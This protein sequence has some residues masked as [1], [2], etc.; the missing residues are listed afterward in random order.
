ML[1]YNLCSDSRSE[2][3][4][5]PSHRALA[6]TYVRTSRSNQVDIRSLTIIHVPRPVVQ[7]GMQWYGHRMLTLF[8]GDHPSFTS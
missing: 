2:D 4:N 3:D 8:H 6:H 7:G 1:N 5:H